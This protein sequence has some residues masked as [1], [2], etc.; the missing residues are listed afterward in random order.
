MYLAHVP[1]LGA[2]LWSFIPQ[3][4][5]PLLMLLKLRIDG[6]VYYVDLTPKV[7]DARIFAADA[8]HP[9]GWGTI[10]IGGFRLGGSCTNCTQG[11]SG[12]R[13][14]NADFNYNGTTTDT[15]NATSGSDTRVFLSSYFVLDVTNPEKDPVLLWVF[16]DKDLGLT[17][18]APAVLRVNS[19][20]DAS[21]SSANEK[22]YVVFGTG[23][24]HMDGSSGQ[25]AKMVVVELKAGPVY[26]AVQQ[27]AGTVGG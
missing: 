9:G 21:T 17:T 10:L 3:D 4:V 12:P 23:P 16:R 20:T 8:D 24:T 25:T 18:A 27:A 5:L 13:T 26:T 11:K 19:L 2:E 7:T 22:W 14:V 1:P 6:H 15:G